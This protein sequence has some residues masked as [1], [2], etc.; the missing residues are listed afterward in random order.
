M[1][2]HTKG[3][4]SLG[5]EEGDGTGASG[6]VYCDNSLGSAVAICFGEHLRFTVFPREEEIANARLIASAPDLL[7][8]CER[9]LE[10]I[11]F[12]Y[13][14]APTQPKEILQ[15]RAAIAKAMG[16]TP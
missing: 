9:A 11:E 2:K 4:W 16:E 1:S 5:G 14:N 8:A 13:M 15:L 10:V 12:A 6:Y 3:P 7:D